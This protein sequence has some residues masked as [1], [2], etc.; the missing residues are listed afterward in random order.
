MGTPAWVERS[1][2]QEL[3]DGEY[4]LLARR[5]LPGGSRTLLPLRGGVRGAAPGP[6]FTLLEG[7]A[8]GGQLGT[9]IRSGVILKYTA[10][11]DVPKDPVPGAG[12]RAF[13][14]SSK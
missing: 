14:P 3:S 2:G 8:G 10:W 4:P 11:H 12:G 6:A 9:N 13:V 1:L 7:R 5:G